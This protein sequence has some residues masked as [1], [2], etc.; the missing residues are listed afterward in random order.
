MN[1]SVTIKSNKYGLIVYLRQD[2]SFHELLA[3]VERTF[4]DTGKFFGRSKLA[5]SF[6]GRILTKDQ[7]QQLIGLISDTAQIEIVCIIDNDEK[8]EKMYKRIVEN[9]LGEITKKDGLFCKGTLRKKQVLES[10]TS[11]VILGDVDAGATIV[12]KGNVIV[13]G[14]LRGNVYAGAGTTQGNF[15]VSLSMKPN[16]L[17]IGNLTAKYYNLDQNE[18]MSMAPMIAAAVGNQIHFIPLSFEPAHIQEELEWAK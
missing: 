10:E 14:E 2:V 8:R 7:E 13:L 4:K 11:V 6:E 16:K 18:N 5:I 17:R 9:C 3:E 1:R 12:S 15:I